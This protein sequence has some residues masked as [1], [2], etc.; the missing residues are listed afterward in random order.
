MSNMLF[1]RFCFK[2]YFLGKIELKTKT[3]NA[4]PYGRC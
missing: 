1:L 3:L 2:L 4:L